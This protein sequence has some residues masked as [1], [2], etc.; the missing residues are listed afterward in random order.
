MKSVKKAQSTRMNKAQSQ[1]CTCKKIQDILLPSVTKI[2]HN[3][4]HCLILA[5]LTQTMIVS[6]ND[7][8]EKREILTASRREASPAG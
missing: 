6:E 4:V 5:P 8:A 7:N 3:N 2:I 1:Y